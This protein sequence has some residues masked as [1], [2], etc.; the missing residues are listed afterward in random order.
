LPQTGFEDA[1]DLIAAVLG[2]MVANRW[3]QARQLPDGKILFFMHGEAP[4]CASDTAGPQLRRT[5]Q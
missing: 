4:D 5:E 2:H 3:L 1:P